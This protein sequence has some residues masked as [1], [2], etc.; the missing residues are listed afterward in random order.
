MNSLLLD[1][2]WHLHPVSP[3]LPED[4]RAH[5]RDFQHSCHIL[6]QHCCSAQLPAA[7]LG[8]PPAQQG[9]HTYQEPWHSQGTIAADCACCV[10]S[11]GC[12]ASSTAADREASSALWTKAWPTIL[13]CSKPCPDEGQASS[14]N[15]SSAP[16][17]HEPDSTTSDLQGSLN[18]QFQEAKVGST[19]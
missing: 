7:Q 9:H 17:A 13:L 5:T 3:L 18:E 2:S 19:L 11:L 14:T 10:G 15:L 1:G 6:C 12:P 4:R 8:A 16:R